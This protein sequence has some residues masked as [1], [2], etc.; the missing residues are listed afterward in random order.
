MANFGELVLV[1][2]DHHIP[3]R[4]NFIP[5]KFR[6]ML[7][8]NKMQ[9][10]ICT[11]NVGSKDQYNELRNLAPNLHVVA[12]DSECVDDSSQMSFADTRVVQVGEFRIGL[13]HGHQVL[14]CG[15]HLALASIRRKLNVDILVSGHTHKN[16]VVEHEGFFHINPGSITGAY[17]PFQEKVIP[18]FILLAVQGANVVCY[19]YELIDD[20]LEVSKTEFSKN[21]GMVM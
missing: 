16:E 6:R 3:N 19:V 15:D 20:E 2:G 14:P 5:E 17:S 11:G 9:H 10:I 7:V 12:G 1:L 4:A 21:G 18:S 13:I 8:P